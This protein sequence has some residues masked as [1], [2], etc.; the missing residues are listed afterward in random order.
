MRTTPRS[1]YELFVVPNM[2]DYRSQPDDVRLGFNAALSAFQLADIFYAFYQR[3]RPAVV[4]RWKK[5][6]DLHVHLTSVEPCYLACLLDVDRHGVPITA[7]RSR[8]VGLIDIF[9]PTRQSLMRAR[10]WLC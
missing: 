1:F 5:L 7:T 3:E 4:S 10:Q 2:E 9:L 6:K 8:L